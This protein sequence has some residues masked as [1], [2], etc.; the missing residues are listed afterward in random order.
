M[1]PATMKRLK[2]LRVLEQEGLPL[3]AKITDQYLRNQET[4]KM[5]KQ[6]LWRECHMFWTQLALAYVNLFKQAASGPAKETLKPMLPVLALK[7][8][9]TR[10]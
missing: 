8:F 5:A 10:R 1:E 3:Q 4:L 2:A 7:A 6:A 9:V